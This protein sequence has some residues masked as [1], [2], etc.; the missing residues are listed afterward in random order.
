MDVLTQM[1]GWGVHFIKSAASM[2]TPK[3]HTWSS[4]LQILEVYAR[5]RTETWMQCRRQQ[6]RQQIY[7]VSFIVKD[8]LS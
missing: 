5:A 3:L 6:K 7:P 8:R 4:E 2:I 1:L